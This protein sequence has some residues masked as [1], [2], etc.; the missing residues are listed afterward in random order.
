MTDRIS[1]IQE[2]SSIVVN[3]E[4]TYKVDDIATVYI[5]GVYYFKVYRRYNSPFD[6]MIEDYNGDFHFQKDIPIRCSIQNILC[7]LDDDLCN[8]KTES[9]H[10][11]GHNAPIYDESFL[12]LTWG[13]VVD[14]Y[15][16][17]HLNVSG[18]LTNYLQSC[19][20]CSNILNTSDEIQHNIV[21]TPLE[22]TIPPFT[23]TIPD[24]DKPDMAMNHRDIRKRK[25]ESSL[26]TRIE[27][28]YNLRSKR[29]RISEKDC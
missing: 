22:V 16:A 7:L 10:S 24:S 6:I 3:G 29:R 18:I 23:D 21:V 25:R 11:I 2:Y 8:M 15:K 26:P 5:N 28:E 13:Q 9:V 20:Y 14:L 27:R 1:K 19:I 17:V 12:Y 4:V